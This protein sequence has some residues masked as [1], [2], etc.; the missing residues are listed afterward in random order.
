MDTEPKISSIQE[1][2]IAPVVKKEAGKTVAAISSDYTKPQKLSASES[3]DLGQSNA[4]FR[5]GALATQSEVSIEEGLDIV[6]SNSK[7]QLGLENDY[8][9]FSKP[10]N[11]NSSTEIDGNVP[12]SIALELNETLSL[13]ASKGK[14]FIVIYILETNF[15]PKLG[16]VPTTD[17]TVSDLIASFDFT[18]EGSYTKASFQ[19]AAFKFSGALFNEMDSSRSVRPRDGFLDESAESDQDSH[20][21]NLAEIQTCPEIDP[22]KIE[23]GVEIC[24]VLGTLDLS[25][26]QAKYLLSGRTIGGVKGELIQAS[27]EECNS[28]GQE[29]CLS[30][31]SFPAVDITSLASKVV[32]GQTVAGIQGSIINTVY[33][34]CTSA[35]QEGCVATST[36]KTMD[37]STKNAGGAEDLTDSMF[38]TRM[39]SSATFE[40]WD[41]Q[42]VRHTNSG[43]ADIIAAN[44]LSGTE[45]FGVTGTANPPPD[46]SAIGVGGTWILV[47]G[48]SDYGTSNFCVMKYEAKCSFSDGQTCT[49]NMGSEIPS[50]TN[51]NTPWVLIS[52]QDSKTECT[53]LGK[54][55]H[56]ITNNVWMT[57]GANIANVDSNWDGGSVGT[58]ELARG[59]SDD[60]PSEACAADASDANGYVETD[61][62]GMLS[63]DDFREKRTHT[64]SNGEVIWD[65][66]GNV[67]EWTSYFNDEEK[68]SDDGTPE[69]SWED[70]SL[71][72]VGT[73]TM[74]V[75]YLIPTNA[76]KPFWDDTWDLD[77]SVGRFNAGDDSSGGALRRG[78]AWDNLTISGAFSANLK[79]SPTITST[80]VGFRCAVAVP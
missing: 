63:G 75:S 74:P 8:I 35:N 71:P 79:S 17:I 26:L 41:E 28:D 78:G 76:I 60:D 15:G 73:T 52:Q 18:T 62:A 55:Y 16:V 24:G 42:G 61:C 47:P 14:I 59:H 50:S 53:S 51:A 4:V 1:V 30:N 36:Y 22:G 46:C 19:L 67:W 48:D 64:L 27:Y 38:T 3:S 33:S 9:P 72:L 57:I 5:P 32:S 13:S 49:A 12:L 77:Q 70:Y 66:A 65:F 68:P 10:L 54:G 44:V 37:L 21:K 43:D 11:I 45:V 56:L 2:E 7:K 23:S 20:V 6:D 80:N 29:N 69:D 31:P 58:N 34:E 40:Y 39:Q 25:N